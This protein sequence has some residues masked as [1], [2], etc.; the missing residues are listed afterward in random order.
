MFIIKNSSPNKSLKLIGKAI[1]KS[2]KEL[3][4]IQDSSQILIEEDEYGSYLNMSLKNAT[5]HEQNIFNKAISELLSPMENPKYF[6][7]KKRFGVFYDY[8]YSLSCPSIFN[9]SSIEILKKHL[10]NAFNDLEIVYTY[11][12][13]G[14]KK[15]LKARKKSFVYRNQKLIDKRLKVTKYD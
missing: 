15:M 8:D 13:E 12:Y 2:L 1:L 4:I 5:S 9:S 10:N 14:R 6:I 11:S 3:D 7:I